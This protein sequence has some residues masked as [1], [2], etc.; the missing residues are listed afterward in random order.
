MAALLDLPTELLE[1]I[2]M[3]LGSI[4]DVHSFGRSYRKTYNVIR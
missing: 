4:D 3:F 1:L 2:F